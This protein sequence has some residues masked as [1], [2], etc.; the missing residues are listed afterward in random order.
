VRAICSLQSNL[1]HVVAYGI[2]FSR[3]YRSPSKICPPYV[4]T[5]PIVRG[6][7]PAPVP[8]CSAAGLR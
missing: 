3:K 6:T 2:P 1:R 5:S 8:G 4:V 7:A